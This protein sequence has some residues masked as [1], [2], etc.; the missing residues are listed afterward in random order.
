MCAPVGESK[1]ARI[2]AMERAWQTKPY[3]EGLA[4]A[5]LRCL[6]DT[7]SPSRLLIH[8]EACLHLLD[9]LLISWMIPQFVQIRIGLDCL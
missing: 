2:S 4:N 5:R 9:A 8:T 6:A 1:A 3:V 7:A